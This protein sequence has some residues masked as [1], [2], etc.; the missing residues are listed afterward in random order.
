MQQGKVTLSYY[1]FDGNDVEQSW[2][3]SYN[4]LADILNR[5]LADE[6]QKLPGSAFTGPIVESYCIKGTDR[7]V[8]ACSVSFSQYYPKDDKKRKR[9][10]DEKSLEVPDW[11]SA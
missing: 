2:T 7:L 11:F 6:I 1:D 4:V 8:G 3:G 5:E 10:F 9:G